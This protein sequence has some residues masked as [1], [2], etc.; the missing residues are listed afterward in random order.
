[1]K[2]VSF[3]LVLMALLATNTSI[4]AQDN[5]PNIIMIIADDIGYEDLGSYGNEIAVTPITDRIATEGVRFSN[6]FL[7]TSSCSPSRS[8]IISG[9]YPHNTGAAE[10]HTAMPEQILTFPELLK[11][12]GYFTGQS[13]KWHMGS[14]PRKGFDV[15]YD[16]K[17][18]IGLGGE[19]YW[20]PLLKERPKGKP[21]FL[22]LAA[23]DAHRPW[24]END[25]SGAHNPEEVIV[26]PYLANGKAT[27]QDLANYYDEITRFDHFIGLV[28]EEL[29]RQGQLE[30]TILFILSDNGRPFPRSKTRLIDSGIKSP[31]LVKWP[32]GLKGGLTTDALVSSIDLAP[33]FLQLAGVDI[34]DNFQGKSFLTVLKNPH[35]PFRNYVFAEHNWHDQE[36]HERMVRT[37]DYLYIKNNR[38][39]YANPGPADSNSSNSYAD[40]KKLRDQGKLNPAQA[41]IFIS[42]RPYEEFYAI[43]DDEFQLLNRATPIGENK[44]LDQL[45]KALE[46]WSIETDDSVPQNLTQDWYDTETGK[47]LDIKRERGEMPGGSNAL[48]TTEKGPF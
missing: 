2:S 9:R 44:A 4:Y 21:F 41:D 22:W 15:I 31:L 45:R 34:P 36:A 19:D 39:Q 11:E 25:F 6:F 1:M 26:P 10:L 3:T 17:P 20:V 33:T 40:L 18:Q 42:P 12:A 23:L 46:V 16:K 13:G 38:A 27:K 43:V 28:E 47:A 5:R 48:I 30:N 37:K 7:T 29:E 8:S 35:L 32:K 14:V 24:A